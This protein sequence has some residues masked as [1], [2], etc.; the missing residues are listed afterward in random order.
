MNILNRGD[1]YKRLLINVL[2]DNIQ[3][4]Y[5]YENTR[6]NAVVMGTR[7]DGILCPAEGILKDAH[8][9]LVKT[10]HPIFARMIQHVRFNSN[11]KFVYTV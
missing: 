8:G 3:D 6:A 7:I 10:T 11:N 4:N 5:K 2:L 1:L 9:N